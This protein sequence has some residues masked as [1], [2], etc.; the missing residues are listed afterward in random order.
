MSSTLR[1]HMKSFDAAPD[2]YWLFLRF[3]YE[4][5]VK[6]RDNAVCAANRFI[7][8]LSPVGVV[9]ANTSYAT[10]ADADKRRILKIAVSH[11]RK[12]LSYVGFPGRA[13]FGKLTACAAAVI[14][15]DP[16]RRVI[17]DFVFTQKVLNN[18]MWNAFYHTNYS[19]T[20]RKSSLYGSAAPRRIFVLFFTGNPTPSSFP[21][22]SPPVSST[23]SSSASSTTIL[24][25]AP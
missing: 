14:A 9:E 15:E 24:F 21:R 18:A 1:G 8:G 13:K 3:V 17:P 7:D 10:R 11:H 12:D 20:G 25:S 2:S 6:W 5:L 19:G 23:A 22:R 16:A 4:Q